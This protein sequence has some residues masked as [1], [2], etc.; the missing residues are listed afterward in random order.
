MD[1]AG[2]GIVGILIFVIVIVDGKQA[3]ARNVHAHMGM[4]LQRRPKEI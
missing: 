1:V 4:L 2:M 3:I